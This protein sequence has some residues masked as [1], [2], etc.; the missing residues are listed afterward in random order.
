MDEE[1]L[2]EILIN[3]NSVGMGLFVVLYGLI[4]LI[5]FKYFNHAYLHNFLI[6]PT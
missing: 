4:Q 5:F 3:K 2:P 1:M 6:F